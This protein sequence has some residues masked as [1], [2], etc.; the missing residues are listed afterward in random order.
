[1]AEAAYRIKDDKLVWLAIDRMLANA[2]SLYRFDTNADRPNRAW[3]DRWPS[4]MAY[5][6]A[7]R[8]AAT[9]FG[10]EAEPLLLKITD[11]ETQLLVRIELASAL[12]GRPR[13]EWR[14]TGGQQARNLF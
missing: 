1:M 14:T 13:T 3:R 10:L 6:R 11:P 4:T 2:A 9:S 12:L 7:V 8:R 5:R